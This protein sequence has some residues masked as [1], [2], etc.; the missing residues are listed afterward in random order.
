MESGKHRRSARGAAP[1][2]DAAT[3]EG[4][5]YLLVSAASNFFF[6]NSRRLM[7]TWHK[8]GPTQAVSVCIGQNTQ[9]DRNGWFRPK[10]KKNKKRCKTHC[11]NLITNPNGLISLTHSS[12]FN[13]HFK[14]QFS[15]S[16][17]SL[18]FLP[19]RLCSP[20]PLWKTQPLSHT[21]NLT[22]KSQPHRPTLNLKIST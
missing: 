4:H 12:V 16:L 18:C 22:H 5:R 20:S 21:H 14:L 17:V 2:S 1:T 3:C 15:L 8:L 10:F 7:P 13:L 9:T 6:H 11:L 19:L